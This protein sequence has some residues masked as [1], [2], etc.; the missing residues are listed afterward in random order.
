MQEKI[1]KVKRDLAALG[2]MTPGSLS[3]QYNV[4]GNPTCRCKDLVRPRRHG[5]YWQLS[6]SRKGKSATKFVK[7][8]E[9]KVAREQVK[10]YARFRKLIDLWIDLAIELSVLKRKA[11]GEV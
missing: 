2:D 9:L 8:G 4:C 11:A 3:R 10:T 6:Y 1:E 7:A 5:P